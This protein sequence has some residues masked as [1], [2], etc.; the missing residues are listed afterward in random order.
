MSVITLDS[1]RRSWRA[2]PAAVLA[3]API[4]AGWLLSGGEGGA[5]RAILFAATFLGAASILALEVLRPQRRLGVLSHSIPVPAL[6]FLALGAACV[7]QTLS[8]PSS[9]LEV[10]APGR[11]TAIRD[12]SGG[13]V[14]TPALEPAAAR[15]A[16]WRW[17][18]MAWLAACGVA[19]SR[20][21]GGRRFVFD[22]LGLFGTVLAAPIVLGLLRG[23]PDPAGWFANP[24]HGAGALLLT[25]PAAAIAM[26]R[27]RASR[28]RRLV[29]GGAMSLQIIALFA[30][31]SAGALI[32]LAV[33][34]AWV[35]AVV[36]ADRDRRIPIATLSGV[37]LAG[38]LLLI[39][40]GQGELADR[41]AFRWSVWWEALRVVPD[42][43]VTGTGA[44]SFA[45]AFSAYQTRAANLSFGHP[46]SDWVLLLVELGAGGFL[47]MIGLAALLAHRCAK[48]LE[49]SRRSALAGAVSCLALLLHGAVDINLHVPANALAFA[50]LC[51]LTWGSLARRRER[52]DVLEGPGDRRRGLHRLAPV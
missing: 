7:L 6:V 29:F 50:F 21:R 18:A 35:V 23:V 43:P 49:S 32:S 13:G 46:E 2:L 16:G 20:D 34:A 11:T 14:E 44:G 17:L 36:L 5:W 51:G 37:V 42:F 45:T 9:V 47:L 25:L 24:N 8:W 39:A 30:T 52:S 19:L 27:R 1:K 3:L 28:G 41:L 31:G 38:L 26:A 12:Y 4:G 33:A 15:E 10:V 48:H 22:G 40:S